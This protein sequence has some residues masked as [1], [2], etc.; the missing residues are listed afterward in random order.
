MDANRKFW[1]EQQQDL[2]AALLR[3]AEHARAIELFLKQHAMVHTAAL[4]PGAGGWSFADEV[5]QGLSAAAARRIPPGG[6]HSAAWVLWHMAR[7]EDV[8]MNLLL[9]GREQVLHV[10]GWLAQLR[11]DAIDTGNRTPLESVA[12]LSA[13][14]DLDAL[15]AYRL[16]VARQTRENVRALHA[17]EFKHSIDAAGL[18]RCLDEGAVI[19]A[20][21]ELIDYWGG[22][23]KAGLLLMPPTRHNFLHLNEILRIRQ[24]IKG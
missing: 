17:G 15:Y 8:T 16:A 1:N 13:Q 3:P 5:W 22:L 18:Q 9:A 23:N 20:A 19:P 11:V 6:E 10:Q 4:D 7:I 2:R 24:K 14:I 12:G 21:R